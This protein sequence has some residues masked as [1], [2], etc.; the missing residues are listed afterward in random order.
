VFE[1][2]YGSIFKTGFLR[3]CRICSRKFWRYQFRTSS[4]SKGHTKRPS[5]ISNVMVNVQVGNLLSIRFVSTGPSSNWL[6]LSRAVGAPIMTTAT[7]T[8]RQ[9]NTLWSIAAEAAIPVVR[10]SKHLRAMYRPL[11]ERHNLFTS[12]AL[13]D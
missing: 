10:I 8:G 9:M 6:S 1:R 3:V 4:N 5:Y 7:A 13:I 12:S 2:V 11:R